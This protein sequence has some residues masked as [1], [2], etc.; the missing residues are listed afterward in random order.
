MDIKNLILIGG[1]ILMAAIIAHGLWIAWRAHRDP[2]RLKIDEKLIA[3]GQARDPVEADFPNGGA[4]SVSRWGEAPVAVGPDPLGLDG[5]PEGVDREADEVSGLATGSTQPVEPV[6]RRSVGPVASSPNPTPRPPALAGEESGGSVDPGSVGRTVAE[7]AM[8]EAAVEQAGFSA[9][10]AAPATQPRSKVTPPELRT[11]I[12][13]GDVQAG[14]S[15]S[16][17]AGIARRAQE[18]VKSLGNRPASRQSASQGGPSSG[19]GEKGAEAQPEDLIII[20]V[21][22]PREQPFTG[23]KLVDALRANTLRYGEMNIFHRLDAT[24]GAHQYSVANIIEPGTFDMAE[25]DE[26]RSPG[27]CFFMR[28]PGPERPIEAFED[29]QRAAR[30]VAERLGGELKD[31]RRS[32]LTGQT[33]EHY[34]HRVAEFCRRRMSMRA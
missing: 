23:T 33:V 29:M 6:V 9:P 5:V 4:R 16:R 22:A 24:S 17:R 7:A 19:A 28:L 32:V 8:L 18:A 25:V 14:K 27:L 12:R 1:G 26:I 13:V 11:E 20:N 15:E 3:S 31:E 21:L 30:D 10:D 34:R 2:L